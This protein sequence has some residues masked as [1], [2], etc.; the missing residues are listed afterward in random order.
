MVVLIHISEHTYIV[1]A[2]APEIPPLK[3]DDLAFYKISA[4]DGVCF[5]YSYGKVWS[6]SLD[7]IFYFFM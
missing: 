1:M 4:V 3:A 2:I 6:L 5:F 7:D